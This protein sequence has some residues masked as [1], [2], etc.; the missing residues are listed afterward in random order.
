MKVAL[1]KEDFED[2]GQILDFD[3]EGE[4]NITK[5]PLGSPGTIL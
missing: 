2:Q 5:G 3:K 1:E 4:A